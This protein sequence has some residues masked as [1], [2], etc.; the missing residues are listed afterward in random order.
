MPHIG[1]AP[2][3]AIFLH[4]RHSVGERALGGAFD[5]FVRRYAR[6]VSAMK[7]SLAERAERAVHR[8]LG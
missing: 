1:E 3:E 2:A 6:G 7:S 5:E 4:R 8:D